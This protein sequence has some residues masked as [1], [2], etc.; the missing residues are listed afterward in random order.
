MG[1]ELK[2]SKTR[3]THTLNPHNGNVG[4]DFLGFNIRQHH[5][6]KTHSGKTTGRYPKLLG[7]KTI[8]TPSKE[9][10]RRHLQAIGEIIRAH[11]T[12]PQA[13]LIGQLNRVIKGWTNY[14]ATV[15][16]KAT[17]SK[18]AYL[19]YLK[20]RRWARRRHPNKSRRWVSSKY[21]RLE[22]GSWDFA[23]KKGVS[24]YRHNEKPIKRHIK[25]RGTKSPYDGDW[26]YWTT[27]RKRHPGLPRRIARLLHRQAG[28]CA[29][30]GLYFTAEDRPEVDHVIP[31]AEG[32]KDRYDNWQLLHAH[33][34]HRKSAKEDELRRLEALMSAAAMARSR[35]RAASQV[36]FCAP[37]G[38]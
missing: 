10:Q 28:K 24:L 1:L 36:R 13:R 17:F 9:A 33:C 29:R 11:P 27:R 4:F 26:S 32:G 15:S 18:M 37:R 30:C 12:T 6:G 20:L 5:V 34:H 23:P 8:I 21:W 16:S 22:K 3:I 14:Y 31:R 2:P 38:A 35:M 19:T 7:F 25:V